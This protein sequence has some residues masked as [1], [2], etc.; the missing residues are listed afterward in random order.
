MT[1][2][3]SRVLSRE[4]LGNRRYKYTVGVTE[5][6]DGTFVLVLAAVGAK[7]EHE[8]PAPDCA[9]RPFKGADIDEL[10]EQATAFL[11][12]WQHLDPARRNQVVCCSRVVT[13]AL[14]R[15]R[16]TLAAGPRLSMKPGPR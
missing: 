16:A 15:A 6:A 11:R 2:S 5:E 14:S 13:N 7:G 10:S 8:M 9:R 1:T 3:A 12:D 4:A